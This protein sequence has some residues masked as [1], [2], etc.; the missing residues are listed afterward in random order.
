MKIPELKLQVQQTALKAHNEKLVA[1]TSGNVSAFHR[2]QGLMVITPSGLDYLEMRPEDV[3]VMKLDGTVIDGILKPSSE[4]RLHAELYKNFEHANAVI[5]THSP[6]ATSFAVIH[7]CIPLILIEML[8]FLGGNIPL[9]D[10]GMPGTWEVGSN[11]VKAMQNRFSCLLANHG[12]V[13]VGKDLK[14]A[15]IRAVYV[16]D[17]A[18]VYHYARQI[19]KPHLVP[20]DAATIMRDKYGLKE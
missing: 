7:E 20:A 16:E 3:V 5:H 17:A 9:A 6:R 18:T 14:E 1:G 15:Y 19:G 10:F 4:W 8:W 12:V 2:E 11:A 13:T